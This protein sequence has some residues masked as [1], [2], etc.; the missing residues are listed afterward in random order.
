MVL[1]F[2]GTALASCYKQFNTLVKLCRSSNNGTHCSE[3]GFLPKRTSPGKETKLRMGVTCVGS[4]SRG[5]VKFTVIQTSRAHL[6]PSDICSFPTIV[7]RTFAKTRIAPIPQRSWWLSSH[8]PIT[9]YALPLVIRVR[10]GKS[11]ERIIRA[12]CQNTKPQRQKSEEINDL[13][14]VRFRVTK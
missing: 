6:T 4:K 5:L 12:V 11:D 1:R 9:L 10:R 13:L 14:V 8:L 2:S 7:T 3:L